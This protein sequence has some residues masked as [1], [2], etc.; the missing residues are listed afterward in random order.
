M[1]RDAFVERIGVDGVAAPP[2]DAI[3]TDAAVRVVAAD[4]GAAPTTGAPPSDEPPTSTST[5]RVLAPRERR[6]VLDD[7]AAASLP[8]VDC[9]AAR[10]A[11]GAASGAVGAAVPRAAIERERAPRFTAGLA[12]GR[13]RSRAPR[14][15][16]AIIAAR[17]GVAPAELAARVAPAGVRANDG[18]EARRRAIVVCGGETGEFVSGHPASEGRWRARVVGGSSRDAVARAQRCTAPC[19]RCCHWHE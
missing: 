9:A 4:V 15:V 2:P 1:P 8:M 12:P 3:K 13:S 11:T 5:P 14:L 7:A 16:D 10:V 19:L 6:L 18:M 17:D